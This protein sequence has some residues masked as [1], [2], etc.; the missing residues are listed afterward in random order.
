MTTSVYQHAQQQ[1]VRKEKLELEQGD[2]Y[3]S[4]TG[5]V[6]FIIIVCAVLN[7]QIC[8]NNAI[9]EKTCLLM[10]CTEKHGDMVMTMYCL[11]L[12]G[13]SNTL[14]YAEYPLTRDHITN[15]QIRTTYT[16]GVFVPC[17]QT[18][19]KKITLK[20]EDRQL[21]R[22]L[23]FVGSVIVIVICIMW[24]TSAC[25][26]CDRLEKEIASFAEQ[27]DATITNDDKDDSSSSTLPPV[28]EDAKKEEELL[29]KRKKRMEE[30]L[31]KE[32]EKHKTLLTS[33]SHLSE[34]EFEQVCTFIDK[35]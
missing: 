20:K 15:L 2:K 31:Q 3:T 34:A 29:Q 19:T 26:R 5:I 22:S 12:N 4:F 23:A 25:N 33:E 14:L 13:T 6:V 24:N 32:K 27:E 10:T 8:A 28:C 17:Y 1:Q 30:A 21:D 16:A 7:E 35:N 11:P 18:T 9:T